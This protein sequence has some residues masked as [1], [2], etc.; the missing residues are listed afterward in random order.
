[1]SP[2]RDEHLEACADYVLGSLP[3]AER[4]ALEE[5][6]KERCPACE[7]EIH[8]LGRGAWAFAAATPRLLE[9]SALR[10]RVLESLVRE[11][12]GREGPREA[13][14][15]PIPFPRR[16]AAPVLGSLAALAALVFGV[17]AVVEWRA[18]KLQLEELGAA[19]AEI[20]RLNQ[21][22]ERER[23]WSAIATA[24]QARAIELA[25]TPAGSPR[26]HARVIYDPAT[27][28]AILTVSNFTP[29]AGKDYQ[30]WAVMRSGP[31]SLGLIHPGPGGRA[32]IRLEN[33][34]DPLTLTAFAVSLENEGGSPT[35]TAASGPVILAGK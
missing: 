10:A 6:L 1:M 17:S 14:R 31:V 7:T 25:P 13:R 5:H 20:S 24:P 2:H 34:G 30:L 9:P 22:I 35:P 16:S 19:H 18:A 33:A 8:R 3:G 11:T 15:A 32:T 29:Q 28:Q 12:R 27:R 26:L 4:A 21:E 23:Q